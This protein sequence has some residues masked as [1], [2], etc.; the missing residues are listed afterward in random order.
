M[1]N[2]TMQQP[3]RRV[4]AFLEAIAGLDRQSNI[5]LPE[6]YGDTWTRCVQAIDAEIAGWGRGP[7]ASTHAIAQ[8]ADRKIEDMK[9]ADNLAWAA[10]QAVRAILVWDREPTRFASREVYRPFEPA[11]PYASLAPN[12]TE[13]L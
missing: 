1:V 2:A 5:E 10:G 12:Q 7:A 8:A 9:F 3:I 6:V 11:I 4:N 13:V